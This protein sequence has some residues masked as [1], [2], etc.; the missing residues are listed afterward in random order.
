MSRPGKTPDRSLM[1]QTARVLAGS[2]VG[3]AML[4]AGLG[5]TAQDAV[6]LQE[7]S[8]ARCRAGVTYRIIDSTKP[9]VLTVVGQRVNIRRHPGTD[10]PVVRSVQ[11]GRR[12]TATGARARTGKELWREVI[13]TAGHGWVY[14]GLVHT[15]T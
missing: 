1:M 15:G 13:G 2:C 6:G 14:A 11:Q 8:T 5:S 3:L 10:C 4:V 7:A 9:G 12:L